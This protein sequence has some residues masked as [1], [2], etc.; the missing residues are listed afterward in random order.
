MRKKLV[1]RLESWGM[2]RETE[3]LLRSSEASVCHHSTLFASNTLKWHDVVQQTRK[4]ISHIQAGKNGA[5]H[6]VLHRRDCE[7]MLDKR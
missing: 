2:W 4:E 1:S 6:A 3:G 5:I 7:M